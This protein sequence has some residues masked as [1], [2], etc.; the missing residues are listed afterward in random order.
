MDKKKIELNIEEL[1]ERIAPT[2]PDVISVTSGE[3]VIFNQ[4][5]GDGIPPPSVSHLH[6][7][8]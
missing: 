2:A 7:F 5:R 1:E 3:G 8:M 4:G 6:R